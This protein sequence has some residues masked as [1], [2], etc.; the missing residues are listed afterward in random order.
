MSSLRIITLGSVVLALSAA[1]YAHAQEQKPLKPNLWWSVHV[2][3]S[4]TP[5]TM[6]SGGLSVSRGRSIIYQ[7]S[8]NA[9]MKD[10]TE[11]LWVHSISIGIAQLRRYTMLS[12]FIG[13]S[14]VGYSDTAPQ[15]TKISRT[16]AGLSLNAQAAFLPLEGLGLGIDLLGV[17]SPEGSSV[18]IRTAFVFGR[19]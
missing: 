9:L 5:G 1:G 7:L 13:P 8:T 18:T 10:L 11:G 3:P 17:V 2:G 12:V 6:V 14:L 16:T 19:M 4:V 15:R